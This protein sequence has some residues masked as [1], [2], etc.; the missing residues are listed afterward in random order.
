MKTYAIKNPAEFIIQNPSD[1]QPPKPKKKTMAKR[2][3]TRKRKTSRKNPSTL[4]T[5][6]SLVMKSVATVA[7]TIAALK[8]GNV[9]IDRFGGMIPESA[10]KYIKIGLP[11]A[12]GVLLATQSKKDVARSVA[13]G[14]ISAGVSEAANMVTPSLMAGTQEFY[15]NGTAQQYLGN[16]QKSLPAPSQDVETTPEWMKH[17]TFD[18]DEVWSA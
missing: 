15:L 9:A 7:G 5:G 13:I 6:K 17:V 14:M 1:K 4:K 11:M 3:S 16:S 12:G 8:L 18:N 2:K 10:R